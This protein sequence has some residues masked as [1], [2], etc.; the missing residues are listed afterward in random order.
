MVYGIDAWKVRESEFREEIIPR[1]ET[2]FALGNG[3][4]GVRGTLEEQTPL[5]HAATYINGVYETLPIHYGEKAFGFPDTKQKMISVPDGTG[6]QLTIDNEPFD[7]RTGTVLHYGRELDLKTGTVRRVVR[8]KSPGGV[9][10]EV[11]TTRLVSF[12]RKQ[13]VCFTWQC[14]VLNRNATL[15]VTSDVSEKKPKLRRETF[16]PR[17]GDGGSRTNLIEETAAW[18]NDVGVL[19]CSTEISRFTVA[20][21]LYHALT[22]PN[23]QAD[24]IET[25]R[26]RGNKRI[27]EKFR[28]EAEKGGAIELEKYLAYAS[29]HAL[30]P[31]ETEKTALKAVEAVKGI[32]F[33]ELAREQEQYLVKFW[34][35]ADIIIEGEKAIQQSMRFSLFHLLD[36]AGSN[37][38]SYIPAKGLTG[39]GYEGHYFWDAEIYVLPFFCYTMPGL[40]KKLLSFRYTTLEQAKE[41]A[42]LLSH[43]GALYPWRTIDGSECS[44]YFLAGTAQYHVNADIIY[45]LEKYFLITGDFEQ[46]ADRIAEIAVE[47]ARFWVDLG[48]YV[49]GKGFCIHGV[50]GPDEYTALVD[51]NTYTNIMAAEQLRFACT[52]VRLLQEEAP[53][54]FSALRDKLSLTGE[55]IEEWRRAAEHMYLP[56]DRKRGLYPQDDSF[57]NKKVWD[58]E[59]TPKEKYPLLLHFHPLNIYRHQVLKQPDLVLAL[60]L[61][62]R[63]FT[64]AEKKRNF[65]FYQPLTTGDSSLGPCVQCIMAGELGYTDLA[66]DYFLKTARMDLDDVNSNT[67]DGIHLAALGGTWMSLIYGFAGLRDD[68]G[69]MRF[70]P[71]LPASWNKLAFRLTT[72][73]TRIEVV[74]TK[75]KTEYSLIEGGPVTLYHEYTPVHIVEEN[76]VSVSMK[77]KLEGVIFDLD[78]VITDTAEYHYQAWKA[79]CEELGIPFDREFN[80]NLR[81]VGRVE[82]LKLILSRGDHSYSEDEIF[83]LAEQKNEHYKKLIKQ[84]T[85]DD[86]LPGIERLLSELK[87]AGVKLSVA[88]A[89][90]NAP[91]VIEGLKIG[92]MFDFVADAG[93]IVVGKPDPEIFLTSAEKIAVPVKNCAGVEDAEAGITAIR[94]AGMF[95]V[96]IGDYLEGPHWKLTS[97]E[98]LTYERLKDRF[99]TYWEP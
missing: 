47:T 23:I 91:T 66:Y 3:H 36:S 39:D 32:S 60:F 70:S 81:G 72:G 48:C 41:R 35:T 8:W 21:S 38:T 2:I 99:Y 97:T 13:I 64:R 80:Q 46:L 9:E 15:T 20:C 16:D 42:H 5:F 1:S 10:I 12:T 96:G 95:S 55:E 78:G 43:R 68:D 76:S 59:N 85:P 61:Q 65:D 82:S 14:T 88:S 54:T 37:G 22:V 57:F 77:P 73:G 89:S 56:Y 4:I 74:M 93:A 75:E 53:E 90:R 11:D 87:Q 44:A 50:T 92:G 45:A 71:K 18:N 25:S 67:A 98:E 84:I 30:P 28:I 51:N 34:R 27:V 24:K 69:I 17:A 86:L 83:G 6:I 19:V 63:R 40:A 31:A 7:L 33:E 94:E 49:E 52:A 29:S 79:L 26:Q 62:S 58:F